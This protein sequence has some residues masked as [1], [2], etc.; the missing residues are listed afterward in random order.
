MKN[1]KRIFGTL[2]ALVLSFGIINAVSATTNNG[3]I[4]VKDTVSGKIYDIYRIFD[5]TY[6]GRG[7]KVAYTINSDWTDFFKIGGLGAEYIVSSNNTSNSLNSITI[8]GTQMYINITD[9]N[10]N[11]F[12][13][14]ALTYIRTKNIDYVA[15]DTAGPDET[16]IKFEKL[17]LGYYLVYPRGAADIKEGFS[18]ICSLTS[19]T[20]DAEVVVK[21]TYPTIDK[22]VNDYSVEVGQI[23]T[24]TITGKVPVTTGYETYTYE[25]AD[26]MS[27]GLLFIESISNLK[28]KFGTT[29]ITLNETDT[30]GKAKNTLTYTS[31][32]FVLNFDMTKYQTYAGQTITVTY[33]AKVTE[34]AVMSH[35]TYNEYTLKYSNDPKNN[36]GYTTTPPKKEYV[37]SADI[38]V[39]KVD[40]ADNS[41]KLAGAEFILY[42]YEKVNGNDVKKYYKANMNGTTLESVE[43]VTEKDSATVYTT[44][45]NGKVKF[46]GL[47]DGTYYLE[48]IKAPE[49]YN[50]L[51]DV[52]T[53]V[54]ENTG[55]PNKQPTLQQVSVTVEN[56]S[57]TELPSTGGMGTTLFVVIGS[58]MAIISAVIFVVNK[59]ISKEF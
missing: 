9:D 56:N 45:S 4:T 20:P 33:D 57:G 12:S 29:E 39:I 1:L 58:L 11:A 27:K 40:A 8:D 23:V 53:V 26:T 19:T 42:K 37:Y 47:E 13:E 44:D 55:T 41:I 18:T 22:T 2:L 31:N 16:T 28:V 50:L 7:S 17:A 48:E 15:T 32:G 30:E 46:A 38:D 35:S 25:I 51:T 43:W 54:V 6:S 34:D 52:K 3:S 59:R 5:L 10:K 49:G 21:A 14:K 36:Q 24:F